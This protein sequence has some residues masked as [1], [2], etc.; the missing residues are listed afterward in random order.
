MDFARLY[1]ALGD[2]DRTFEWIERAR[3]ERRG[4]VTYLKVEPPLD[5]IRGDPRYFELVRRMRLD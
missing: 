2:T 1:L 3:D 4:W 5:P